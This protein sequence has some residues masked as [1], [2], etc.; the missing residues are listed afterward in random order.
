MFVSGQ[1]PRD[2]VTGAIA[3]TEI[4]GQARQALENLRAVLEAAGSSLSQCLKLTC[5][6]TRIE[7]MA[8]FNDVYRTFFGDTVPTRTTVEVSGLATGAL[9]E[10]DAIAVS[11]DEPGG[12]E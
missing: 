12:A 4:R 10:I 11:G 5:Y 2:P 9:V 7:D 3:A 1:L 6:L 8:A